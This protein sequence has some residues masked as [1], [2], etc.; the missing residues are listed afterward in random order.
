MEI[1]NPVGAVIEIIAVKLL[2]ETVKFCAVEFEFTRTLPKSESEVVETVIVGSGVLVP[3]PL[4]ATFFVSAFVL[5]VDI[6]PD[7]DPALVGLNRT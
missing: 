1:S 7:F 3:V 5:V 6:F 4:T 2:P